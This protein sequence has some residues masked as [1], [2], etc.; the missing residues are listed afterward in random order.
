MRNA[1]RIL[2]DFD[3]HLKMTVATE[4]VLNLPVPMVDFDS[5]IIS[6]SLIILL[7]C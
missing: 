3:T 5:S 7:L 1:F 6:S 4:H 2:W